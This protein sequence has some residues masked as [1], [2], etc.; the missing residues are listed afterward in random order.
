MGDTLCGCVTN[1]PGDGGLITMVSQ[2][3]G[4]FIQDV[5][6]QF[7]MLSGLKRMQKLM[8]V[9]AVAWLRKNNKLAVLYKTRQVVDGM[10]TMFL[11]TASLL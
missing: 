1:A 8:R 4:N 9:P 2:S 3:T 7:P 10:E 6:Q 5:L 11:G